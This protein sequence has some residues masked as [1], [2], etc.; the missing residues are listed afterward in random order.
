MFSFFFTQR[1]DLVR[2]VYL[3]HLEPNLFFTGP[4]D[5]PLIMQMPL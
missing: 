1:F 4:N 3:G 2:Q 5:Y